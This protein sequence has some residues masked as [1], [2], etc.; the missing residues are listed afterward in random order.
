MQIDTFVVWHRLYHNEVHEITVSVIVSPSIKLS[1]AKMNLLVKCVALLGLVLSSCNLMLSTTATQTI[2][3][4][5]KI[6]KF[7]ALV[8]FNQKCVS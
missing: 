2:A 4:T 3:K 5:H 6:R 1:L 8:I 7:H